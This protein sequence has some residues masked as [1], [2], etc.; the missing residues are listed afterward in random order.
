MRRVRSAAVASRPVDQA[1]SIY[2]RDHEAAAQGGAD[3]FRRAAREQR[4]RPYAP[5]LRALR[6]EVEEDLGTLRR[7]M[8]DAGV[9][10]DPVLGTAIR[11]AERVGRLKPNG[12]LLRRAP[13]SDLIEA[14]G[15]LDAV[16]AK[17]SGW[18]ALKADGTVGTEPEL[19]AL[20]ARAAS[21]LERLEAIH[22]EVAAAVL[23]T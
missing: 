23:H 11:M 6:D 22:D 19:T 21:Q 13:L 4:S 17:A 14:E 3:L 10:P 5:E 16:F 1:L 2:L 9:R 20:L 18:R 8:Q 15:M 7:L 12:S